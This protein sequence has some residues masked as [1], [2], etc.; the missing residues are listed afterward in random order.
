MLTA[1]VS[2]LLMLL[3]GR[4]DPDRVEI[5][6]HRGANKI[7]PENTMAAARWCAAWDVDWLEVDVR[8]SRDGVFYVFHDE[9]LNRVTGRWGLFRTST[10][11]TIDQL[12]AG[13]WFGPEFAGEPIPRLR[14]LLLWARGR[15]RVYLDIKHADMRRLV[16]LLDE[17]DMRDSVFVWS[18]FRAYM[19]QLHAIAPDIDIKWNA[20]TIDDIDRG[21]TEVGA[22]IVEI[23]TGV[24]TPE[25]IRHAH[26]HGVRVMAH[27]MSPDAEAF[28]KSIE[29]GADM[30]NLDHPRLFLAV[31]SA[32][33]VDDP[34]AP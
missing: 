34:E 24:L 12:E 27:V 9:M 28:R 15:I 30:I 10:S 6:A 8:M 11:E 5:V 20:R 1:A 14:D 7:A 18:P 17:T 13:A 22:T 19:K 31:E 32:V 25:V 33:Q 21:R 29:L 4:S 16:E 23:G 26:D 2:I 3:S